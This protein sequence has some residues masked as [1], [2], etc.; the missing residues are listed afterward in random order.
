VTAI[1]HARRLGL[2]L[3][4][5][6]LAALA[7]PARAET[8]P[9][10]TDAPAP[11][12]DPVPPGDGTGSSIVVTAVQKKTDVGNGALGVRS[13]L[14]TPF[15]VAAVS[16]DQIQAIA[17]TTID[18]AL[19]YEAGVHSNNSGV[20][21]G[22]T[23]SVRGIA[24]DRTNGYKVDGLPFPYWFQDHPIEDLQDL[25]VLKGAGGFAYGFA[26]PG[27]V[28]NLVT[29]QPTQT[30]QAA[31]TTTWRSSSILNEH[32]DL[33]GPLDADGKVAFR[34][35]A[36]N[37]QGRLY[38][39]AY[40]KDQFAGLALVAHL[41]DK[42]SVQ[43]DG[44]YQRTRQDDQVNSISITT[45][46][47]SLAPVD[48]AF[49]PGEK[50]TTK[51]NDIGSLT[52]RVNYQISGD[53]KLSVAARYAT[54]DE[55]FPGSLASIYDNAG[56]YHSTVYNMNRIFKYYVTDAGLT[57]KFA[58]GPITHQIVAGASTLTSQ[59]DYDNPTRSA[60]IAGTYN[61][62]NP[63][64]VPSIVG[65]ATA[66][67]I[68]RPPVWTLY[69][70][71]H[72]RALFASDTATWG[73]VSALVGLRYTD[74]EEINYNPN[75]SL[76]SYFHYH[77]VS[78]VYS[79][80]L[81]VLHGVRL[82]A[83]YV[84]A[85]QRGALAP[86]TAT[87]PNASYGPLTSTQYEAG[88]KAEGRWGN[89]ALAV[90][91][92]ATP[93]EYVDATNT[94]VRNGT[95]RYQGIEFNAA[96]R[97]VRELLL[98]T[99]VSWLD[100]KQVSGPPALI[101]Q[102]IAGTVGFQAS[103]LA[104]YAVPFVKDLKVTAGVRHSGK[105]YGVSDIFTYQANTEGDLGLRYD[106][107]ASGH[108]VVLRANVQ[109]VTNEKYWVPGSAGTSISAGAPRTY[110][111]SAEVALQKDRG[112]GIAQAPG[113]GE[114]GVHHAY[115]ELDGGALFGHSFAAVVNNRV[116]NIGS[117]P[118][119]IRVG[120]KTGW[121]LDGIVGYDLGRF[122]GEI[123]AGYKRAGIGAVDY[124]NATVAV[125]STHGAG[126]YDNAAGHT[127]VLS[128]LFNALVNLGP[129]DGATRGFVGG[130]AGL[131][132]IS[133]RDWT[134]DASQP[135]LTYGATAAAAATPTYFSDD[136]AT[137]FAWQALAGVRQSIGRHVDLVLKYRY[138][139]VPGLKL[140]TTN[141]NQLKGNLFGSS[142]QAGIAWKL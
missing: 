72:Q 9:S 134:L 21:S 116:D 104:E 65:N 54:L 24:I 120:Q 28:V 105:A 30:F 113:G 76:T 55:R 10:A 11:P 47:T 80:D 94:F 16:A 77:P 63:N 43:L 33:G 90:Y 78:P 42:V 88:V 4:G 26:A 117:A 109:N 69:Q 107:V 118:G 51:Q 32:I 53:W 27:G 25:Q 59:F 81:T 75:E 7:V 130:G 14:D 20:A 115:L 40:N 23:F 96:V 22:N 89:A 84:Q 56:D 126:V 2:A 127:G 17:A 50:G 111:F 100:A 49:Q 35:N 38:N 37:E 15:S 95:A 129:T 52:G 97:P 99:S 125:D 34:F 106:L 85:I 82:Y 60:V 101:G 70:D 68:N 91:R 71:I 79:L 31:F 114:D 102:T 122:S 12:A 18:A 83:T 67:Y 6:S 137:G 121:D 3:G 41:S 74:Y 112:A 86:A 57:G 64:A 92:I 44:F 133:S 62:Y 128:V 73:P 5:V 29:R 123:E 131:A 98:N 139:D 46:V 110:T 140:R 58:T 13:L 132:R 141:A 135:L 142:I 19:N 39:G 124:T 1:R 108:A 103:E 138:F 8:A 66:L 36:V 45:A 136:D 48:G 119:A 93:S 61:I 87:N